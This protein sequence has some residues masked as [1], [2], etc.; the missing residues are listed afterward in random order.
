MLISDT[1]FISSNMIVKKLNQA[2]SE[3]EALRE[4]AIWMSGCGYDF[5]QHEYWIISRNNLLTK[6]PH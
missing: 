5:R 3:I 4:L 1:E 2:A 6:N